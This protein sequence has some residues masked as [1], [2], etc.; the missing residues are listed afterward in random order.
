LP[1][2]TTGLSVAR[3]SA[4]V[5]RYLY[6]F[7]YQT[8]EQ[9][10][11]SARQGYAEESS[12]A[13]FIEAASAEEALAWGREISEE[14]VRRLFPK[15]KVSWKEMNFAQWVESAPQREYPADILAALPA[16]ACGKYPDFERLKL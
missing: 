9:L 14:F 13:L 11:V 16:V 5:P 3:D 7:G 15:E 4:V 1:S 8:P 12:R 6:I 10:E 2:G